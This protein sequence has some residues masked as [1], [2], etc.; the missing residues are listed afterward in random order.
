MI[1]RR[2][3]VAALVAAGGV[4]L[5]R[6]QA[7]ADDAWPAREL[8]VICPFAP[9]SGADLMSRFYARK[10]QEVS[11]KPVIVENKVGAQGSIASEYVARSKPDG[12][13]IY[14]IPGMN[15]FASAPY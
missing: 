14:I 9:G 10:L 3:A 13:T 5:L 2:Q 12:Y 1:N 7:H 8:R 4:T 15:V 11:G 6:S